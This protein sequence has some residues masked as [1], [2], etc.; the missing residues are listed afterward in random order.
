[1][2]NKAG[3]HLFQREKE[4]PLGGTRT[5]DT[6]LHLGRA[7]FLLSYQGSSA[8]RALCLQ[9]KTKLSV[10][11]RP[12]VSPF[13]L[14]PPPPPPPSLPWCFPFISILSYLFH[15]HTCISH[16]HTNPLTGGGEA[17]EGQWEPTG[18]VPTTRQGASLS[19]CTFSS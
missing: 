11:L 18:E 13:I 7:L 14:H 6:L 4:L 19:D 12:S 17:E 8:G 16:T 15:P 2:T 1:M 10:W 3:Q 9:H 5:H